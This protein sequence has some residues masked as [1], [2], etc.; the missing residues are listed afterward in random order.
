MKEKSGERDSIVGTK[1]LLFQFQTEESR[2][3][4]E[5]GAEKKGSF[6]LV[7]KNKMPLIFLNYS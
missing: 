6:S 2:E 3:G 4:K 1:D 7:L 5:E